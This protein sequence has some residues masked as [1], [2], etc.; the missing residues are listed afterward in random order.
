MFATMTPTVTFSFLGTGSGVPTPDRF[1]SSTLLHLGEVH[2]LVDAGEPCVHLLRDRGS[3]LEEIGAVLIT[4]GHVDHIGGLPALLQGCM[5]SGRVKPLTICLPGEMI[6]PLR[7]WISALYLPEEGL[8]FQIS[9]NAWENS[10]AHHL[11]GGIIVTPHRN[12]HLEQCY[13]GIPGSDPGHCCDSF[14]LHLEQ[15]GFRALFSGDL[16]SADDLSPF[17]AASGAGATQTLKVLVSELSHFCAED[18][19]RVLQGKSVETLCLVHLA[20]EYASNRSEL[21]MRMEQL[22]PDIRD[23][24]LP[25]DGDV[26]D[27]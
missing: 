26:L 25:E 12:D 5:L 4:H 2:L 14:S 16:A 3:L 15:G 19:A 21:K 6:A 18:L 10:V 20:E 13:R 9:W 11:L 22:L 27:F 24:I 23:V 1:F 17:L 8:G 7:A